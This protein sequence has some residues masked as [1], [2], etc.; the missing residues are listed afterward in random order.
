MVIAATAACHGSPATDAE[1][2]GER[3][4]T[5]VPAPITN[6]SLYDLGSEWRDQHGA[7]RSLASLRGKPQL[8][9]LVYTSCASIC[10]FTVAA[11]QLVEQ[12]VGDRAGYVLVSLDPSNDSPE[13][14]AEYAAERQ[15]TPRWTLLSGPEGSVRELAALIGVKYRQVASGE[16]DHSSTLTIL[17]G[18]GRIVAQFDEADAV[19]R[20]AAV[21]MR[22]PAPAG[23]QP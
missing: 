3:P 18:D 11:M 20:A 8:I 12:K 15:L 21:L 1:D 5:A 6:Y 14:L 7:E 19:D 23:P 10:P 2:T 17:D 22:F 13:R 16:I 4:A 9:S